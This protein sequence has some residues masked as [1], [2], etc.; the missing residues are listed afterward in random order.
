VDEDLWSEGSHRNCNAL[1]INNTTRDATRRWII[2]QQ[3]E[4]YKVVE[5]LSDGSKVEWPKAKIEKYNKTMK[6]KKLDE[7]IKTLVKERDAL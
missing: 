5:T 2:C 6:R 4:L 3:L 7:Q 1:W